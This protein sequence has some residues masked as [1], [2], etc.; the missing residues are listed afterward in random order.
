MGD[1]STRYFKQHQRPKADLLTT[2]IDRPKVMHRLEDIGTSHSRP[3]LTC[4]LVAL[5]HSKQSGWNP[6]SQ[7]RIL[8][9]L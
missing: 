2:A 1:L 4:L 5:E 9:S 3:S 7:S 8:V 6:L